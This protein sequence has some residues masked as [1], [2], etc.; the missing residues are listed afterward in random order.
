[1]HPRINASRAVSAT[2]HASTDA[3]DE[4]DEAAEED[5]DP[6]KGQNE[7]FDAATALALPLLA[8]ADSAIDR[9]R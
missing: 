7:Y 5:A 8:A 2:G 9:W 1:M 3:D 6:E 4:V